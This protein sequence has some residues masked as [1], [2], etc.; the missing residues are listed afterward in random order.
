[1][2]L[3]LDELGRQIKHGI[4]GPSLAG[5]PVLIRPTA[6]PADS[7]TTVRADRPF[8][9]AK[10]DA[11]RSLALNPRNAYA[12]KNRAHEAARD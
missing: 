9:E 1:M 4:W 7:E 8:H 5:M 2:S 11:D 10:A 12:Y 6:G 3:N